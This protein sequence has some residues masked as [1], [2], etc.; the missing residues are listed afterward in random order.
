MTSATYLFKLR[1]VQLAR[2]LVFIVLL[3]YIDF[4]L[5][6]DYATLLSAY[7]ISTEI[8]NV[9][10]PS[11]RLFL[12]S[13]SISEASHILSRRLFYIIYVAPITIVILHQ[14]I[15]LSLAESFLI[16]ALSALTALSIVLTAYLN[17]KVS[18]K[19]LLFAELFSWTIQ[20]FALAIIALPK[21]AVAGFAIYATEALFRAAIY[22][23]SNKTRLQ[24][25]SLF[26]QLISTSKSFGISNRSLAL[27]G[28]G[29]TL[30]F[31]NQIPRIPFITAAGTVDPI[32]MIA[33]QLS[34]ASYN[35]LIT[36]S[37]KIKIPTPNPVFLIISLLTATAF[38]SISS[39]FNSPLLYIINNFL[40]YG[41]AA[42]HGWAMIQIPGPQGIS[43]HKKSRA[44]LL[45]LL[46]ITTILGIY[47]SPAVFLF[48]PAALIVAALIHKR[49]RHAEF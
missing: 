24:A 39:Q 22:C 49:Y 10:A 19:T 28:E 20:I 9:L 45:A 48:S 35:L 26:V 47:S 4:G 23:I 38:I 27:L 17:S 15:A 36:I 40:L 5:A 37:S 16:S 21:N 33:A 8:Y 2:P 31:A 43:S 30:T 32:Y 11:D 29:A 18:G 41:L 7:I 42:L 34:A 6:S 44:I 3:R 46:L 25:Q 13:A 1:L 14:T 12:P